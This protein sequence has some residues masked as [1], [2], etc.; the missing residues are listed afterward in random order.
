[1]P[2]EP[3]IEL[4]PRV[5]ARFITL[6]NKRYPVFETGL[7]TN[8]RKHHGLK[9]KLAEKEVILVFCYWIHS[10]SVVR[11]LLNSG[12]VNVVLFCSM[13]IIYDGKAYLDY[14]P[15]RDAMETAIANVTSPEV[16]KLID[17]GKTDDL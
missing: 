12:G 17:G 3:L 1:M 11:E 6:P 4:T 16:A 5:S 15:L 2:R 14:E 13:A 8:F 7:S 9:I 10:I